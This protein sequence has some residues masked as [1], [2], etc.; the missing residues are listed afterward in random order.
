[1]LIHCLLLFSFITVACQS[2]P[3]GEAQARQDSLP[4]KILP[5]RDIA[6]QTQEDIAMILGHQSQLDAESASKAGCPTC[7]KYS[8]QD[9]L[10]KIV[11]INDMADWITITPRTPAPARQTPALLGLPDAAPDFTD[12]KV[13]RWTRYEGIQQISAFRKPDGTLDYIYIKAITP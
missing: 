8:Y 2:V 3:A 12:Q 9:G 5:I 6:N 1:M 10:V 11:Y 7:Q 13:L 4:D